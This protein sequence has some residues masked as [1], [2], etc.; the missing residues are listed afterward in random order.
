MQAKIL[1]ILAALAL[2]TGCM[3]QGHPYPQ[4]KLN[5]LTVV[6]V[7]PD[8]YAVQA[9]ADVS[10]TE[11]S[12]AGEYAGRADGFG[13]ITF[14][15]PNGIY[16]VNIRDKDGEMVFNATE[17]KVKVVNGPVTLNME[18]KVSKAGA[19]VIKEI[20]NGGCSKAPLEGTYQ[21][22]KYVILH[23]NSID[24]YYLDGLCM[25][26]LS[27]YNSHGSGNPWI[28]DGKLPDF[29]PIIQ[30]VLMM[31][32]SGKDFPLEPGEDAI[33]ALNG[34][35]D[36]SAQYP[37]SVD[38]NRPEVFA[39]YDQTLFP[40]T[41]YHP[42]PGP[43]VSRDRYLIIVIKT[44]QANAYTLSVTSPAF[45][46][47][48]TP[49]D[50]NIF[51]YVLDNANLPQVPGSNEKVVAIPIDWVAD[52]VEVFNGSSSG[53]FKR[54]PETVDAGAVSL[55]S[56]FKGYSLMRN[57]NQKASESFGFEMLEDSNNS[58]LDFYETDKQSLHP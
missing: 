2:L 36:H 43:L 28:K 54:L 9:G 18:L 3:D 35:I 39:L 22:D 26:T 24:T 34:A 37:N 29:L 7:Y 1:T 30:A 20:Y 13:S 46:L 49:E 56:N 6:A 19:I 48:R 27:P 8:G 57:V 50:V 5:A 44:G 45:V 42:S 15:L 11:V 38:L 53:N 47:F 16:R 21:S 17:D 51:D 25:G 23:N 14:H 32:G 33:I 12:G 31:P 41:V 55:S 58:T 10:V 52:G 4:E 40:N